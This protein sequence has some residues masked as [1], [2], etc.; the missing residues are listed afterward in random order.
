MVVN[1][2]TL[3]F[4]RC[5]VPRI[6]TSR[7]AF[8]LACPSVQWVSVDRSY[9]VRTKAGGVWSWW[10]F[11]SNAEVTDTWMCVNAS[12]VCAPSCRCCY[13]RDSFIVKGSRNFHNELMNEVFTS[14]RMCQYEVNCNFS[15]TAV[16]L[17]SLEH[18]HTGVRSKVWTLSGIVDFLVAFCPERKCVQHYGKRCLWLNTLV[19]LRVHL[20]QIRR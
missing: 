6:V 9:E 1:I 4:R 20:L 17:H 5:S 18:E 8:E 19:S 3:I 14:D 15:E 16:C 2:K 10:S 11:Q 12:A 7:K 13:P